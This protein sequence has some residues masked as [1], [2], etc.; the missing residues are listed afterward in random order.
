VLKFTKITGVN[1]RLEFRFSSFL[2]FEARCCAVQ[3]SDQMQIMSW[4][5][6]KFNSKLTNRAHF[7]PKITEIGCNKEEN[8][9]ISDK[10]SVSLKKKKIFKYSLSKYATIIIIIN[11]T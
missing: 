11:N 5:H 7:Y 6:R 9:L 2:R 3:K 8:Y 1:F 4:K 10:V